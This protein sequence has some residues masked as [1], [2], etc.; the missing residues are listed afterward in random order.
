MKWMNVTS[1]SV[2]TPKNPEMQPTLKKLAQTQNLEMN[3]A[4]LNS[5]HVNQEN[6]SIGKTFFNFK[7]NEKFIYELFYPV[8]TFVMEIRTVVTAEMKKIA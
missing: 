3:N 6:A 2:E 1:Q 5:F 7:T 8:N 4:H